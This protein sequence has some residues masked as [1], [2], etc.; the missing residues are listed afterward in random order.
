MPHLVRH[1]MENEEALAPMEVEH[2]PARMGFGRNEEFDPRAPRREEQP[3]NDRR[4][5][6]RIGSRSSS[7]GRGGRMWV[8]KNQTPQSAAELPPP[9]PPAEMHNVPIPDPSRME[10]LPI[11]PGLGAASL[12]HPEEQKCL[13][14]GRLVVEGFTVTPPR[15]FRRMDTR[16]P[17]RGG[18]GRFGPRRRFGK[19]RVEGSD[20]ARAE[21]QPTVAKRGR[22][23]GRGNRG[24]FKTR[25][26]M[27]QERRVRKALR[28]AEEARVAALGGQQAPPADGAGNA[29]PPADP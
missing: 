7:R 11:F 16:P 6:N 27:R 28:E 9:P 12:L 23:R 18:R 24:R 4:R 21:G 2:A 14:I 17:G 3:W 1:R 29:V 25:G 19:P 20:P 5:P 13:A 8:P 15:D 22:G 26:Q 10:G